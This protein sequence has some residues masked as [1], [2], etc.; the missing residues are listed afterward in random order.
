MAIYAKCCN[1]EQKNNRRK[2]EKCNKQI[3][4][5]V[6][7]VQDSVTRRWKTKTVDNLKLAKDIESKFKT[8]LIEGNLFD[9]KKIGYID[10]DKYLAYVKLNKKSWKDDNYRWNTHVK[11]NDFH[12]KKGIIKIISELKLQ[13][14]APATVHHVLKLIKRVYNWHIKNEYYF[15]I[16]PCN[17]ISAPKYDNRL[18]DYLS[19]EEIN[20]LLSELNNWDNLRAANIVRFALMTGRRKGE[21]VNLQWQ[22]VDFV[23]KTITCKNTKNGRN[24]SFPLNEKAYEIILNA[25]KDK[26]SKYVFPSSTGNY[27]Y[28]SFNHAWR[29]FKIR[30]GLKCRF[31]SLRHSYASYLASSG[32]QLYFIQQLLG[33]QDYALCQRYAHLTDAALRSA[34][35]VL[36]DIKS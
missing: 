33:H 2:C 18:T 19:K 32:V 30:I 4:K 17:G 25:H 1:K 10:F 13:G 23:N 3:S 11:H 9:K 22:D 12:T 14:Y 20:N 29:R 6:V 28:N 16:N 36:D 24:L 27:Y 31:H 34:N 7:K 21:I 35:N 26:I 15:Q 5:Y 8:E